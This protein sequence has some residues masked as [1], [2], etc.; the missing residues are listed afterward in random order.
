MPALLSGIFLR[1]L[2]QF[3][4]RLFS[5]C[6][7]FRKG[8]F[9]KI[10]HA[11]G[12]YCQYVL[13]NSVSSFACSLSSIF[14][15]SSGRDT[16]RNWLGIIVYTPC[17]IVDRRYR[18]WFGLV[19]S[20]VTT[21]YRDLSMHGWFCHTTFNVCHASRLFFRQLSPELQYWLSFNPLVAPVEAFKY[22]LFGKGEFSFGSL[23]YSF[24]WMIVLLLAGILVF[25]RAEKNFMD[26]VPLERLRMIKSYE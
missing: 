13:S 25:N 11:T 19:I 23:M 24:S 16:T 26:T 15:S 9:S 10:D 8:V 20:S 18:L 12:K 3:F 2:R 17:F 5:E 7:N 4:Q 22:A 1:V 14:M 6:R 21:K